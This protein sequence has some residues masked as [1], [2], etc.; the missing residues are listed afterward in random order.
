MQLNVVRSGSYW[1]GI[2][3]QLGVEWD[4]R[5]GNDAFL[6]K[7]KSALQQTTQRTTPTDR[8]RTLHRYVHTYIQ[9]QYNTMHATTP[10]LK[11]P[12]R[13]VQ[14]TLLP[15]PLRFTADLTRVNESIHGTAPTDSL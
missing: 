14:P 1:R 8:P 2:S 11:R 10:S 12:S 4:G 6:V 13:H 3:V 7:S 9:T 15:C 5:C